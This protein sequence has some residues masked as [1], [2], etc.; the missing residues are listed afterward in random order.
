MKQISI[1][2]TT[3]SG[4][5]SLSIEIAQKIDAIILSLDSLLVYKDINIASAKPTKKEMKRIIHF[6][7]NEIYPYEEFS[8]MKFI[9]YYKKAYQFAKDNNKNL[10]IVGG[11]SFYLKVLIEGISKV[12]NNYKQKLDISSNEAY[13]ILMNID[14]IYM[15]KISSNDKY[16]IQKAY[17]IYKTSKLSP[18]EFFKQNQKEPIIKNIDI[19]EIVW[20][21]D[22]LK[23]R[24]LQRTKNMI[25][26]GLI[27]EVRLLDKK[28]KKDMNSMK[29]IG[30]IEVLEYIDQKI[31]INQ[32]EELIYVHT[33]QLAKKQRT[34]NNKQFN[35]KQI[36]NSFEDLS[37]D[38]LKL[39]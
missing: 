8:V 22:E 24:I 17:N 6:G 13:D 18:S 2:G 31:D 33:C 11:S 35:N 7:I 29:S 38:I 15:Q 32:L 20:P 21:K 23:Q 3:A 19:F 10:I 16:R 9:S 27:D 4:K 5:T 37:S 39:F 14:P 34:F 12:E 36:K 28:Y 26:N 25:Q 30:I 1:I